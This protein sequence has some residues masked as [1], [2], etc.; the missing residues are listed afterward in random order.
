MHWTAPALLAGL[1]ATLP[2]VAFLL[3]VPSERWQWTRRLSTKIRHFLHLLFNRAP[4]GAIALV[5]LLAGFGEEML[6]RGL[7]QE[8]LAQVWHPLPALLIASLLF[9]LAHAV[10]PA[11]WLLASLMGLYL[12]AIHWWSGNLLVVIIVHA[13]YDWIAIHF[14]LRLDRLP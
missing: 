11:Y 2:L 8:G 5:S 10:S 4:F 7:I 6:F 12:G 13:V 14:Y 1:A 3:L 9:G